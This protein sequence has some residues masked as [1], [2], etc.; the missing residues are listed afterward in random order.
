M[1]AQHLLHAAIYLDPGDETLRTK[2]WT[3]YFRPKAAMARDVLDIFK[4]S[5]P[6]KVLKLA[7]AV[8]ENQLNGGKQILILSCVSLFADFDN[9]VGK[10]PHRQIPR[11]ILTLP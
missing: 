5:H 1:V 9:I 11:G 3:K 8:V 6:D 10:L 2:P 7:V 4:E